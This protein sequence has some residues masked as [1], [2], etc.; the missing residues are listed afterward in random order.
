MFD[1]FYKNKITSNGYIKGLYNK[2]NIFN[3]FNELIFAI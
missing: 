1:A 2:D 3:N